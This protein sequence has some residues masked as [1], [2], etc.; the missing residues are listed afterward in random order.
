MAERSIQELK[1]KFLEE[2][3][4]RKSAAAALN[5]AKR[6]TEGQKVLLRDAEDQLTVSKAQIVAL[7][8]K[9]KEGEK[10]RE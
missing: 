8:K 5:S 7:K 2:E 6:Q 4:E 10:A 3:R 1:S 9:L